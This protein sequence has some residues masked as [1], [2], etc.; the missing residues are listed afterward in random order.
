MRSLKDNN[1]GSAIPVIL[2]V[3]TIVVI[4]ALFSLF[5]IEIGFPLLDTLIPVPDSP[6]KTFIMMMLRGIPLIVLLVGCVS[7]IIAGLKNTSGWS[8]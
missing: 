2:F 1:I 3:V 7:L 4:G 6:S 8:A 5:F